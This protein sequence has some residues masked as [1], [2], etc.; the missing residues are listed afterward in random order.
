[1]NQA[2]TEFDVFISYSRK[3]SEIAERVF[4]TL[5]AGGIRCFIDRGISGGADFPAVLAEAIQSSRMLLFVASAN[6]YASQYT[7]KELTFAL[8]ENCRI[9]PLIIDGSELPPQ[10]HF[11]LSNINW[12]ELSA[13]YQIEKDLLPDVQKVLTDPETKAIPDRPNLPAQRKKGKKSLALPL[14]LMGLAV[15]VLLGWVLSQ[16]WERHQSENETRQVE[17]LAQ[18]AKAQILQA[19]SHTDRAD[20]LF[21][22]GQLEDAEEEVG[23]LQ[24]ADSLLVLT[25]AQTA[26]FRDRKEYE[27]ILSSVSTDP[28]WDRLEAVREQMAVF[29][30]TSALTSFDSYGQFPESKTFHDIALR[31]V[32]IALSLMPTDPRLLEIKESLTT[33]QPQ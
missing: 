17:A 27:Y 21:R 14:I 5:S 30:H 22:R 7:L 13:D 6:S 26:P 2:K 19:R 28:A 16:E 23:L 31:Y 29:W 8:H 4:A 10:L 9:L 33:S 18:K 11:L 32:S 3:D 1:M 20:S 15:L 12:R 24:A 25:D